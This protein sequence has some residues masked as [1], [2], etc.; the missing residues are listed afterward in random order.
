[1]AWLFFPDHIQVD[2][3]LSVDPALLKLLQQLADRKDDAAKFAASAAT[4]DAGTKGLDK[5]VSDATKT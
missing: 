5:A 4:L 2:I 1:M 3:T